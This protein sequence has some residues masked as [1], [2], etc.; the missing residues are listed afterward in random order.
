MRGET[1]ATHLEKMMREHPLFQD[2]DLTLPPVTIR[3]S[4]LKKI[5]K[6]AVILLHLIHPELQLWRN[7]NVC[8]V[9]E[10]DRCKKT[11]TI[12]DTEIEKKYLLKSSKKDETLFCLFGSVSIKETKGGTAID[13]STFDMERVL[14]TVAGERIARGRLVWVD[15]EIAVEIEKVE[16]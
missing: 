1:Q 6:G 2:Y 9:V 13:V 8:A 3:R 5:E 12:I 14:L 16:R 15:E 7:G 10:M 4:S 11:V